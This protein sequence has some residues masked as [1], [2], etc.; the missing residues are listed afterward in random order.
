M[1]KI[2]LAL[3][4]TSPWHRQEDRLIAS[5]NKNLGAITIKSAIKLFDNNGLLLLS[6]ACNNRLI[7]SEK[8]IL[9]ITAT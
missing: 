9:K 3:F 6:D 2:V 7:S 4:S 5:S 1:C 8:E